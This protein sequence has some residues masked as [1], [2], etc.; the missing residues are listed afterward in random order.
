[1]NKESKHGWFREGKAWG[2]SASAFRLSHPA[3]EFDADKSYSFWTGVLLVSI[4][5]RERTAFKSKIGKQ[6]NIE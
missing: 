1:L 6:S 3:Q 4:E 2:A 5:Q